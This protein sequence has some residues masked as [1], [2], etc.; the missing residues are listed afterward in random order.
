MCHLGHFA[1]LLSWHW[2][3]STDESFAVEQPLVS[4]CMGLT[5]SFKSSTTTFAIRLDQLG[6]DGIDRTG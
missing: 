3:C 6:H 4:V 1:A 2:L 5:A